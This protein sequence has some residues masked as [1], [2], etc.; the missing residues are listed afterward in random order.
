MLHVR[1]ASRFC[2]VHNHLDFVNMAAQW[3]R[4]VL[5]RDVVNMATQWNR[6]VL[7][8]GVVNMATQWNRDALYRG[9]ILVCH[10][11]HLC[12]KNVQIPQ[13]SVRTRQGL[14]RQHRKVPEVCHEPLHQ[15]DA[16]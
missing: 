1:T 11:P 13:L 7:Y 14:V 8:R 6:G 10:V 3:N 4:G 9:V 5:Y 16:V 12:C 15:Q 2:G